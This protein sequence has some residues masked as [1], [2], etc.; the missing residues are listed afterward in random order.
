MLPFE[1]PTPFEFFTAKRKVFAHYF[2]TFPLSIDNRMPWEDYYNVQFLEPDGES[3]KH[4]DQG[5]FLRQRP[6]A[7]AQQYP[8]DDTAMMCKE[9]E[10]AI[11][12]GITGFTFD[13][14]SIDDALSPTGHLQML[15]TA[16]ARTD[17]RFKI[18]PMPDMASMGDI[19][20]E[21]LEQIIL[22]VKDSRQIYRLDD[23]RMLVSPYN[24]TA[25]EASWWKEVIDALNSQGVAIAFMPTISG[26]GMPDEDM[27]AISYGY[28]NWGTVIP[29]SSA[30]LDAAN[31]H[32]LGLAYML[33][34]GS[35]QYRPKNPNYWEASCS[36]SF[37]NSW[38]AAIDTYADYVQIVTWS[39]FSESAQIQPFTD[40]GL[41]GNIGTG[42]Y[43]LNAFYAAWFAT[44][45]QPRVLR[46]A[47]YWFHRKMFLS[48]PHPNQVDD[49]PCNGG[50]PE[51]SIELVALLTSDADV[52]INDSCVTACAPFAAVKAPLAKGTPHFALKRNGSNVFA[53]DSP[54]AVVGPDEPL[55]TGLTDLTYWCGSGQAPTVPPAVGGFDL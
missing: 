20:A 25:R 22:S 33:P 18:V 29:E 24:A 27:V 48:S 26:G 28:A 2:Y 51:D 11:A 19:T 41:A 54:I 6:L 52:C 13:M 30:N 5:G 47:L 53:F 45:R 38:Q 14:L 35:Q 40:K 1:M 42:F 44:G 12:R 32:E 21:Q 46:D 50:T 16:A 10:M 23:G 55:D 17:P 36:L 31:A 37:R 3:G 43:D 34:I 4:Q 39:D 7:Q 49:T 15:L 9:I 8:R